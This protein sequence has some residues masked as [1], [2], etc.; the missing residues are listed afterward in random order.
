[1]RRQAELEIHKEEGQEHFKIILKDDV[2]IFKSSNRKK[3]I[4]AG[5][6]RNNPTEKG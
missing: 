3:K 1:M 2:G 6:Q 5:D 4:I